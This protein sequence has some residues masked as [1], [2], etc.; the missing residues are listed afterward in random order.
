MRQHV[1]IIELAGREIPTRETLG[2][3]PSTP[4]VQPPA[5]PRA[6]FQ[7]CD[8]C[9]RVFDLVDGLC[10]HCREPARGAAAA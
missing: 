5:Q 6:S 7:F 9:G 4:K 1:V 8:G 10:V 3:V 2:A